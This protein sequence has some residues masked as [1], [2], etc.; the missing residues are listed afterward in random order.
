M[1]NTFNDKIKMSSI[2]S[3][4]YRKNLMAFF[5]MPMFFAC[6]GTGFAQ[7][8]DSVQNVPHKFSVQSSITN[9]GISIIPSFSLGKPAG[10]V[11]MSFGRRFTFDPQYRFSLSGE[12][13]SLVLWLRYKIYEARRFRMATGI[14]PAI[15]FNKIS[16]PSR[17]PSISIGARRF[18][19]MELSPF[20]QIQPHLGVGMYYLHSRGL[21]ETGGFVSHFF[22]LNARITQLSIGHSLKLSVDPQVF[23]LQ[24]NDQTGYFA[25]A[26]LTI[27]HPRIPLSLQTLHNFRLHG[28]VPG[29]QPHIWNVS[30]IHSY[31]KRYRSW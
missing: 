17:T 26:A 2:N 18:L 8:K 29:A 28:Q 12:P 11:E 22:T 27:S 19:A 15:M 3:I 23:I 1:K 16:D 9:N 7:D 25:T 6:L 24:M 10:I 5:L 31:V 4:R 21:K 14:H 20:W 13:W 30:L